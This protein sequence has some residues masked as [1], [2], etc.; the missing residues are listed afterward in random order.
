M[1]TNTKARARTFEAEAGDASIG[2]AGCNAIENDLDALFEGKVWGE[3]VLKRGN[4]EIFNPTKDYDPAT[5]IYVDSRVGE[6]TTILDYIN[7]RV[8]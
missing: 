5:K 1:A 8:V 4:E 6:I 2:R 7:G 3:E